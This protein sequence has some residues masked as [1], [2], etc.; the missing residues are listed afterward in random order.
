MMA[1]T[2]AFAGLLLIVPV[3]YHVPEFAVPLAAGAMAGGIFPDLDVAFEHRRT[4]HFPVLYGVLAVP[5]LALAL[6]WTTPVTAGLAA[7]GAAAWLHAASDVLGG[8]PELD[9]WTNPRDEGVYDHVRGRWLRARRIIRYDGAP[10]DLALGGILA[11]PALLVFD[12]TI[13]VLIAAML[14]VSIAY[15]FVR[16]QLPDLVPE[17]MR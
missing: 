1:T 2:H 14:V 13:H 6:A 5:A 3:A 11:I 12:G 8:G 16:R 4:L 7:F 10:E 17:S 9:P 15:A